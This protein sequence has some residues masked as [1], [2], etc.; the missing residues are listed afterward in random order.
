MLN[1]IDLNA[2]VG[3]GFATDAALLPYLTSASIACGAHAG[4]RAIF[5]QTA[6]ACRQY[7]VA[8]GAHPGFVDRANFGRLPQPWD[9]LKIY[10][11]LMPQLE[12]AA[13]CCEAAGAALVYV[14]PHGA[15][16]N[17]SAADESLAAWI[18]RVIYGFN[19]KLVLV[20]L[21]GSHSV[22][23]AN[24]AGLKVAHEAFA[25]RAYMAN[26]SLAPRNQ[27]GAVL[28]G[29]GEVAKQVVGLVAEKKAY[30]ITGEAV[31]VAADTICLHGDGPHAVKFAQFIHQTLAQHGI[32]LKAFQ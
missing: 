19:P 3:E 8:I 22:M 2:D 6:A 13:T 17:M 9:P 30:T 4:S 15:L 10:D 12:L 31:P 27:P 28:T 25:D 21:S 1:T 7:G 24:A 23:Q 32:G 11:L 14:K 16:Y 26:G 5:L 20:G 29:E 18:A